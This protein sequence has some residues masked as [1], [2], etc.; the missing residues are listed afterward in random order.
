MTSV[1]TFGG[2]IPDGCRAPRAHPVSA[3]SMGKGT[4]SGGEMLGQHVREP[5]EA[6]LWKIHGEY[7]D[8][9]PFCDVHP[10]GSLALQ[11]CQG[12]DATDLFE[13][14]RATFVLRLAMTCFSRRARHD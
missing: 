5:D 12:T 7:Y 10:G 13:Q 9:R 3:G 1:P 11:L 6:L 8:L 2:Y 14:F 4:G